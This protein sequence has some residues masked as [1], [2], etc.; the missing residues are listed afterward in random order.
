M[1][2]PAIDLIDG[3]VVRLHQGN[4]T[5]KRS[6][7]SDPLEKFL[8]YQAQGA[9]FLHLVDLTGAKDPAQ[10]QLA[11]IE[12]I[13]QGIN[14]PIQAGGGIR[15]FS[16][17][18]N[19]LNVGVK[20]VVIGSIAV[21]EPAEV[22]TWFKHFGPEAITL[23]IDIR[24]DDKGVKRVAVSGWQETSA[25]TLETLLDIYIP[26]GLTHVL[27]T[28]I[29]KDGTLAG[30]NVDLYKLLCDEYPYIAFQSSGGIGKL[31]DI[32]ALKDTGVRG[33]IVGRAL[34]EGKFTVSEA[35]ECWQNE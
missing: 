11:L 27:C 19:L 29:S 1:I 31:D 2:I 28:D 14:I 8:D 35:I 24:I 16:D 15:T 34:L 18:E 12:K 3:E 30:S 6:Y 21:T 20:R 25:M 17:V 5:E 23:A 26:Y 22:I 4:Y 13:V 9:S 32:S 33:V 7:G 10:R